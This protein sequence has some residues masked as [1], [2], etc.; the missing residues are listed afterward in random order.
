M[1]TIVSFDA[2]IDTRKGDKALAAL[3]QHY[4]TLF[5]RKGFD[6]N[7][8][9]GAGGVKDLNKDL[10]T[11]NRNLDVSTSRI[12]SFAA[13]SS[14]IF[15]LVNAFQTLVKDVIHVE[16]TLASIQA[17]S[18]VTSST[19]TKLGDSIFDLANKTGVGFDQAASAF[20][21]FQRQGLSTSRS[22]QATAAALQ[23]SRIGATDAATAVRDLTAVMNTFNDSGM[24]YIDVVDRIIALDNSFAVSAQGISEGL[25]RVTGVAAQAGVSF[26]EIASLITALQQTSARGEAVIG[27][28]LKAIFTRVQRPE[29]LAQLEELGVVTKES[30]GSFRN[31]VSILTDLSTVYSTLSDAQ[32]AAIGETVAGVYQINAFQTA[33]KAL[34]PEVGTFNKAMEVASKASGDAAKRLDVLNNTTSV[35]LTQLRNNIQQFNSTIGSLTIQPIINDFAS[36]GNELLTSFNSLVKDDEYRNVGTRIAKGILSGINTTLTGPGVAAAFLVIGKLL[37]KVTKDLA[38]AFRSFTEINS[39]S[40]EQLTLQQAINQEL[41]RGNQELAIRAAMMKKISS[42]PL[43]I[44]LAGFNNAG[45]NIRNRAKGLLPAIDREKRAISMGVGGAPHNAK[46]I[47][48]SLKGRGGEEIA[49]VNSSEQIVRKN[50]RDFVIPRNLQVKN[51]ALGSSYDEEL[52]LLNLDYKE[53]ELRSKLNKRISIKERRNISRKLKNIGAE[54]AR[55]YKNF[56]QAKKREE[57]LFTP[58]TQTTTGVF[59]NL[60]RSIAES[61]TPRALQDLENVN[62]KAEKSRKRKDSTQNTLKKIIE[63]NVFGLRHGKSDEYKRTV[64]YYRKLEKESKIESK[65]REIER[66]ASYSMIDMIGGSLPK[67]VTGIPKIS[68]QE[69]A[70]RAKREQSKQKTIYA[71]KWPTTADIPRQS[72]ERIYPPYYP[73]GSNKPLRLDNRV[74]NQNWSQNA[75]GRSI[76]T[77]EVFTNLEEQGKKQTKFL[78]RITNSVKQNG[79]RAAFGAGIAAPLIVDSLLSV[80]GKR[81]TE[82]G[83]KVSGV[84]SALSTGV[85]TAASFGFTPLGLGLGVA[86]TALSLWSD[87]VMSSSKALEGIIETAKNGAASLNEISQGATELVRLIGETEEL[88]KSGAPIASIRRN[89][90]QINELAGELPV[91][92]TKV[93]RDPRFNSDQRA[94][95]LGRFESEMGRARESLAFSA[96]VA[97]SKQV[98]SLEKGFNTQEIEKAAANFL[99]SMKEGAKLSNASLSALRA[100]K[101]GEFLKGASMDGAISKEMEQSMYSSMV[102]AVKGLELPI[103]QERVALEN[104]ERNLASGTLQL[105]K[106]KEE[107]EAYL[108]SQKKIEIQ[109]NQLKRTFDSFSNSLVKISRV[110]NLERSI[111]AQNANEFF[112]E[113]LRLEP[114]LSPLRQIN[115]DSQARKNEINQRYNQEIRSLLDRELPEISQ[116]L[117]ES[118][119]TPENIAKIM[120]KMTSFLQKGDISGLE[121]LLKNNNIDND[122]ANAVLRRIE[123]HQ[124]RLAFEIKELDVARRGQLQSID[125]IAKL[126]AGAA[127]RA[128]SSKVFEVG[129]VLSGE[130]KADIDLIKRNEELI[131]VRRKELEELV[132][133]SR[134]IETNSKKSREIEARKRALQEEIDRATLES[135]SARARILNLPEREDIEGAAA[136]SRFLEDFNRSERGLREQQARDLAVQDVTSLIESIRERSE[137]LTGNAGEIIGKNLMERIVQEMKSGNFDFAKQLFDQATGSKVIGDVKTKDIIKDISDAFGLIKSNFERIKESIGEAGR[138]ALGGAPSEETENAAAR[139]LRESSDI[140]VQSLTDSS[141]RIYQAFKENVPIFQKEIEDFGRNSESLG[142]FLQKFAESANLLVNS[143]IKTQVESTINV[144]VNMEGF[145]NSSEFSS[146]INEAIT[147]AIESRVPEIYNSMRRQNGEKPINLPPRI[148]LGF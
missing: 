4:N 57:K 114:N 125:E 78:S 11:F 132:R 56:T 33:M 28:S 87:G 116:S 47:V 59:Q 119:R 148:P 14:L 143:G 12:V 122:T 110:E 142:Q 106:L 124:S 34:N 115:L 92:L 31:L 60:E 99:G 43:A 36:L 70:V 146:I 93:L 66:K 86:T 13:T 55:Q 91:A 123:G 83:K 126:Q 71:N 2:T 22:M 63:R 68:P 84:T 44:P 40:K 52:K 113:S 67:G 54:K 37:F 118:A 102:Q 75:I 127:I 103:K 10:T 96:N 19:L 130:N 8:K 50:G 117:I 89:E 1:S 62:K 147:S 145:L 64:Q 100:G 129:K 6:L 94:A 18:Q 104:L 85:V 73:P 95:V 121:S 112:R 77:G 38:T 76:N 97:S 137:S 139:A 30:D 25:R 53:Q 46:P 45:R 41:A 3:Y 65:I 79:G 42:T 81:D 98:W 120:A 26:N 109:T 58:Y 136:R 82:I 49:V 29:V 24:D 21:E 90:S 48:T 16:K 17:I 144:N 61:T 88:R 9:T 74:N 7:I 140:M 23:L 15:G 32:R 39:T 111:N 107:N 135:I 134:F 101:Y 131:R 27:N 133:N 72:L 105:Y 138:R 5:S 35:T 108:E 141:E 80:A 128:S 69:L 51:F 20:E